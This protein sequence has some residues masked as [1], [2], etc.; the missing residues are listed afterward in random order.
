M[1][2]QEKEIGS[3]QLPLSSTFPWTVF[4]PSCPPLAD[5]AYG[6]TSINSNTPVVMLHCNLQKQITR[7]ATVNPKLDWAVKVFLFTK[8]TSPLRTGDT[9]IATH[10]A[11]VLAKTH[12]PV[13]KFNMLFCCSHWLKGVVFQNAEERLPT[14]KQ[15]FVK[16]LSSLSVIKTITFSCVWSHCF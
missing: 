13:S 12:T 3:Q 10:S 9:A 16:C 14:I 6:L 4:T 2:D 8:L 1:L 15:H 7:S 5:S 11:S